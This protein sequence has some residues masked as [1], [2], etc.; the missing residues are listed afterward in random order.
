MKSFAIFAVIVSN[1]IGFS[2]AQN[3]ICQDILFA[4]DQE[5]CNTAT[6]LNPSYCD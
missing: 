3:N 4:E 1:L 2:F 5:G 6:P